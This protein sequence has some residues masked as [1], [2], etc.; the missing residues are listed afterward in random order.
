MCSIKF[1]DLFLIT[2]GVCCAIEVLD[3]NQQCGQRIGF[4]AYIYNGKLTKKDEWPWLVGFVYQEY[5]SLF[6]GGSLISKKHVLSGMWFLQ[7]SS[8]RE[9]RSTVIVLKNWKRSIN[10]N[11]LTFLF[12]TRSG[13]LL[14]IQR[15]SEKDQAALHLSVARKIRFVHWRWIRIEIGEGLGHHF[16]S[17]LGFQCWEIRGGHLDGGAARRRWV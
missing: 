6:C 2:V 7:P 16:A 9:S 14:S 3:E 8:C 11:E 5:N 10:F 13:S 12:S 17:R 1:I 4:E 15:P